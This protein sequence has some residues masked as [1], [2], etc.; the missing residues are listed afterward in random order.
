M[1]SINVLIVSI[2]LGIIA[3]ILLV[4]AILLA[5]KDYKIDRRLADEE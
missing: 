3:F 2:V 4:V 1:I 5:I